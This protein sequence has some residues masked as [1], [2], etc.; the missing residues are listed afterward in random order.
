MEHE[1]EDALLIRALAA[2]KGVVAD[3]ATYGPLAEDLVDRA[4]QCGDHEALVVALRAA[5]WAERAHLDNE[6]SRTL[7]DESVRLASRHGL[8]GRLVE[9][10]VTRAAVNLELGRIT[11]AQRDLDRAGH[12]VGPDAPPELQHQRAVLDQNLGRLSEAAAIYRATLADPRTP[13]DV[14]AKMANNLAI[15]EAQRGELPA[16]LRSL[17]RAAAAA[18]GAGPA[19][20]AVVAQ[21]TA[22]VYVQAGRLHEGISRFDDAARRYA[23]AGLSLGEPFIEQ[24]DAL[25]DLRLLP[26]ARELAGRALQQFSERGIALMEAEARIRQARLLLLSAEPSAAAHQAAMAAAQLRAQRRFSYAAQATVIEAEARAAAGDGSL[27]VLRATSRAAALLERQGMT[28]DAVEAHLAAGRMALCLDREASARRGFERAQALAGRAPVLTRL[29]GHVAGAMAARLRGDDAMVVRRCR[30]GLRDLDAYRAAL[31]SLELRALAASHGAELGRLGLGA[32]LGRGSPARVLE[33][34]ER[35][36]AAAL[37][38][39][40]HPSTDGVDDDLAALRAVTDSLFQHRRDGVAPPEE[41]VSRQLTLETR[42]RRATWARGPAHDGSE[43][44]GSASAVRAALAGRVLVAFGSHAGTPF[45]VVQHERAI[46]LVLL[47]AAAATVTAEAASL[48]FALRRLAVP[49]PAPAPMVEGARLALAR[50]HD[51]LLAPLDLPPG[52]ELVVVPLSAWHRIPWG[53]LHDG[54]VSVAPSA[55]LWTTTTTRRPPSLGS[56]LL[57]AGPELPGAIAEVGAIRPLYDAPVALVPPEST[58][59]AVAD[60]LRGAT[61]AH[62]ACHGLLRADNPLFSALMLSDGALSVQELELRGIAPHRMLLAAC[63]AAAD[64]PYEGEEM[65]GFVSALFARG[66]AGLLA[67]VVTLPDEQAVPLMCAV[68]ASLVRGATM[69]AALHEARQQIER[70]ASPQHLV[71][72]M[73][74]NAYGAA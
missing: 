60:A 70:D 20:A 28:F 57:V 16:A 38:I 51:V 40:D 21:T 43:T 49:R 42:I 54:V 67:S 65:L 41:L 36:R 53:A 47:P 11:A 52:S 39:V 17:V 9:S 13:L 31:G 18:E 3:P 48:L 64:T 6:R 74:C 15:I 72:W 5:A 66:T 71:T 14:Q 68:H 1:S 7:L 23:A 59:A 35:T 33:W 25:A 73:A 50:L 2:Y 29:K 19:L 46:R 12:L 24:A 32:A 55:A 8:E 61:L 44:G 58:V 69:A 37:V 56:V 63:D 26:E 30:A 4:R 45:A 27:A 62:L 34:M 22:S 10:L